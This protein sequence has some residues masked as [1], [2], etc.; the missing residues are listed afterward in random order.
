MDTTVTTVGVGSASAVPDAVRLE[1][2]V[3]HRAD[4]VADALAGC[5][6]GVEVFGRTARRF[7]DEAD[8]AT[9][10]FDVDQDYRDGEPS[11]YVATHSLSVLCPGF[12]RAGDLLTALADDVGDR[13]AVHGIRPTITDAEP[14]QVQAREHAFTDARTKADELAALAGQV[15][16]GALRVVEGGVD[17]PVGRP[18]LAMARVGGDTRLEPGTS[19]VT[20]TVTVTWQTSPA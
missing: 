16:V 6:S 13:L 11:G 19:S 3:R 7:T 14:L 2:A 18:E 10:S 4:S 17:H 9:R 5:A 12:E 1:V 20:A 8:I 15:V